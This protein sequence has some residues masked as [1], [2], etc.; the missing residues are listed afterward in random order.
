MHSQHCLLR[1]LYFLLQTLLDKR[2]TLSFTI[3]DGDH[4]YYGDTWEFFDHEP[5]EQEQ[6]EFVIRQYSG[7]DTDAETEEIVRDA[8]E[9][10]KT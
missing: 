2:D 7:G 3:R 1:Q 4:E 6:I 10:P 9:V 5:T 8:I